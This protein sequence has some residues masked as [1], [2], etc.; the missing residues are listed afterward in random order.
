MLGQAFDPARY[1]LF[2]ALLALLA[3]IGAALGLM[4]G[5]LVKDV[6]QGQQACMPTLIPLL[7]FS[8]YLIPFAQ[9]PS[10]F[11]WLYHCSPFAYAM[12]ALQVN[13]HKSKGS[14]RG[15]SVYYVQNRLVRTTPTHKP[16]PS[17][18]G[19][20]GISKRCAHPHYQ[21]LT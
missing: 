12:S 7:L 21:L 8:G 4:V 16:F 3:T 15:E 14:R 20:I 18:W 2:L 13:K 19:P 9:I 10:Y 5:S 11:K 1:F 6:Q 17:R